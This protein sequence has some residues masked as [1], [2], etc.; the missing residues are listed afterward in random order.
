M[1]H[2]LLVLFAAACGFAASDAGETQWR[3]QRDLL[4]LSVLEWKERIATA[5][6]FP[7]DASSRNKKLDVVAAKFRTERARIYRQYGVSRTSL[8]R[9]GSAGRAAL[10]AYLEENPDAARILEDLQTEVNGLIERCEGLMRSRKE[11]R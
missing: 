9:A 7:H 4:K 11:D 2:A 3:L 1:K 10:N 8:W 5:E 6:Q